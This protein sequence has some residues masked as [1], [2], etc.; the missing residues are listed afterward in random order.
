MTGSR[1]RKRAQSGFWGSKM[2]RE[3]KEEIKGDRLLYERG[4]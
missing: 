3:I 4:R 1:E 2:A